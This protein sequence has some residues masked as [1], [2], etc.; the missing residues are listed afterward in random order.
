MM[1]KNILTLITLCAVSSIC[2]AHEFWLQPQKFMLNLLEKTSVDV[3]V[4]EN[5]TGE[6]VDASKFTISKMMHYSSLLS[7]NFMD[8]ISTNDSVKIEARFASEGNHLLAFNNTNKFIELEANKFNEYLKSEGL[9]NIVILRR[10]KG[11]ENKNGR[12]FYQRCVKTLFQVGNKQDNTFRKNTGMR[13]EIIPEQNPYIN[14]PNKTITFKILFD[15]QAVKNALVLAWHYQNGKVSVENKRT[16][17]KGDVQFLVKNE[18][19]WMISTVKMIP[20]QNNTEVDYQ[21]FWG[22]YTFGFY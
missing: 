15:N 9:D 2:I 22:S 1:K 16:S 21:S 7:E 4:G 8:K 20:I 11:E 18:G 17:D 6:K 3:F 5:Y 10:Q 12:E 19:R 13:L 14:S